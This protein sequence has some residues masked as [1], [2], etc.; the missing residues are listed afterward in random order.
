MK[1]IPSDVLAALTDP[2][3][4]TL[5]IFGEARG[6]PIEGQI[7]VGCL[8]RN[9]VDVGRWGASYAK[10]CLAPWQFSCWR[11][12][13]GRANHAV[14]VEAAEML[15]RST[16]LPEDPLLRQAAWVS[17][18]VIGRWIQD[19][20]RDATHYYAP[21]AMVPPGAV[22]RWAVGLTPVVTL[23]RHLFFAGVR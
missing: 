22:P 18:G 6:E 14:V 2:Q 21:A 23:G 16:T 13:G 10:V 8:I 7:A 9:R 1:S 20:T 3:I 4:L 19:T 12:E 17:Q 11:P 15:A 5:T